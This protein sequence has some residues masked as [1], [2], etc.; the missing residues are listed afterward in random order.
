MALGFSAVA[1][2][3]V[4]AL[5]LGLTGFLN[6]NLV[7]RASAGKPGFLV[8]LREALR[9]KYMD[10]S[11]RRL[12]HHAAFYG[13]LLCFASTCVAAFYHFFLNWRAPY[14]LTSVPVILGTLG[15]ISL[16][17][18]SSG[19]FW[20]KW[21]QDPALADPAHR[22]MDATF[23][24]LLWLTAVTGLALLAW[25]SSPAMSALLVIHLAVVLALF[26]TM[27]YGKFVHGMYR[28]AALVRNASVPR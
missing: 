1:L 20:M 7:E 15:G 6:E 2:A 12:F 25:R 11:P 16:A 17:V 5:T 9:L 13:F 3:V 10:S 4:A 19:L 22:G 23:I 27:P 26:V 24:A 14:P 28:L 21:K 18:G 8:A